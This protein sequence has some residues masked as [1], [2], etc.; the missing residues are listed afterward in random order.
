MIALA[1]GTGYAVLVLSLAD[2]TTRV[3]KILFTIAAFPLTP[4]LMLLYIA[5]SL[6]NHG[7][8]YLTCPSCKNESMIRVDV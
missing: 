5:G 2:T 4:I 1:I 3:G 6:T 7:P 8:N